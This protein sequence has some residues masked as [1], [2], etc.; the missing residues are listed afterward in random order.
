MITKL[1]FAFRALEFSEALGYSFNE[2]YDAYQWHFCGIGHRQ[3]I[4]SKFL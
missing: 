2:V 4:N 3:S 1:Y